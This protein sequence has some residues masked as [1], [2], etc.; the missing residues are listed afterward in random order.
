[1]VQRRPVALKHAGKLLHTSQE[2][3]T[4]TQSFKSSETEI[5]SVWQLEHNPVHKHRQAWRDSVELHGEE[6]N[7]TFLFAVP[8]KWTQTTRWRASVKPKQSEKFIQM[9]IKNRRP[10]R[11]ACG[12]GPIGSII[13]SQG[14]T[15]IIY[16]IYSTLSQD[17][18][19]GGDGDGKQVMMFPS[20]HK[21]QSN[22]TTYP[23]L[24]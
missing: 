9:R 14:C 17:V 22:P 2:G 3:W 21:Q 18:Q 20:L 23:K 8:K 1:M 15:F 7:I 11:P 10:A 6:M 5:N 16:T 19:D 4:R 13:P 12:S 24:S